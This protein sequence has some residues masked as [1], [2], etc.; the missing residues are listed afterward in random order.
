MNSALLPFRKWLQNKMVTS[1]ELMNTPLSTGRTVQGV[2]SYVP[3]N[4]GFPY[5]YVD[6]FY[7]RPDHYLG[8]GESRIVT[9]TLTI[10]TDQLG[11]DELLEI[12]D[13]LTSLLEYAEGTQ[14]GWTIVG[15]EFESSTA[16]RPDFR[17]DYDDSYRGLALTLAARVERL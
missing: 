5:I 2:L 11:D 16:I 14:D 10:W 17:A 6:R 7:Q 1:T 13:R 3:E 8:S 4:Q 15:V 9:G 12:E